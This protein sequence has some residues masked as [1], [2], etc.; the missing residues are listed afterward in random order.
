MTDDHLGWR[1]RLLDQKHGKGELQIIQLLYRKMG[2]PIARLFAEH[3]SVMPNQVTFL[4]AVLGIGAAIFFSF[5]KD[6]DILIGA[7]LLHVSLVLDYVDGS[8]AG[9][10]N[11][12]DNFG[13]WLDNCNDRLIDFSVFVGIIIGV[14]KSEQDYWVWVAGLIIVGGRFLIDS[15]YWISLSIAPYMKDSY[16]E[17]IANPSFLNLLIR[18]CVYTRT[19]FLCLCIVMAIADYLA[20]YIVIM[21]IY[22]LVWYAAIMIKFGMKIARDKSE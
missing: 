18:Q 4:S 7:L 16:K 21:A 22:S 6:T 8:L 13:E 2:M 5:G 1:A 9:L 3:T 20:V 14:Q 15:T 10:L 17:L 12:K 11:K 19:S